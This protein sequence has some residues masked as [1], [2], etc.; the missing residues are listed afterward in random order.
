MEP[1]LVSAESALT[2]SDVGI[3]ACEMD[4]QL[5][6]ETPHVNVDRKDPEERLLE[7]C[8]KGDLDEVKCLV[9]QCDPNTRRRGRYG[10]TPLNEACRY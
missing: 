4:E 2:S 10:R 9:S 1:T 3:C 8:E 5:S 7:A 6:A